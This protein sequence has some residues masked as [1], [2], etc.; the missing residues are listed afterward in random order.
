MRFIKSKK[1]VAPRRQTGAVQPASGQSSASFRRNLTI[2]RIGGRYSPQS[3]NSDRQNV[4]SLKRGR[5][6]VGRRLLGVSL[7]TLVLGFLVYQ[8]IAKVDIQIPNAVNVL[9][10]DRVRYSDA[11]ESYLNQ[12]FIERTRFGFDNVGLVDYLHQAGFNEIEAVSPKVKMSGLGVGQISLTMRQ[13]VI[14]WTAGLDTRYV[15]ASG[16]TFSRNFYPDKIVSVVDSSGANV[17]ADNRLVSDRFLQFI[18]RSVGYYSS[19]DL[20]VTRVELPPGTSH[21][22]WFWLESVGYPI[23]MTVDRPAGGQAEDAKR[24]IA[25]LASSG[26]TPAEYLD[27]RVASRAFYK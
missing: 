25:Y 3:A 21:Q 2:S 23:K 16:N 7:V 20:T 15:D 13:P 26:Q 27:V 14:S 22:A 11:V 18:G 8:S 17:E 24:A 5:R 4:H 6:A 9:K 1:S 12:H 19:W 10:S